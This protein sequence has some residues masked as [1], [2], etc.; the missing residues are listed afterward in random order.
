[1]RGKC[2]EEFEVDQVDYSEQRGWS[3]DS[4]FIKT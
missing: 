1:M 3:G 4:R 2:I